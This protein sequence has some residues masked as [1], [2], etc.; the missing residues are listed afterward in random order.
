MTFFD[1]GTRRVLVKYLAGA[2]H[3]L[4]TEPVDALLIGSRGGRA[5]YHDLRK[6]VAER[7][8]E[9][10]IRKHLTPHGLRHTFCTLLLAHGCGLKQIAEL[11]GHSSLGTTAKYPR[12]EIS[13]LSR[14]YRAAHPRSSS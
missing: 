6:L 8:R 4:Q 13:E 9:A 7:A 12:V 14:V 2:W 10:G 11:V 5:S 3:R 1:P